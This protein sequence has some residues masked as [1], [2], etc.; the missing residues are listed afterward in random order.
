MNIQEIMMILNV[1][2][3]WALLLLAMVFATRK[4]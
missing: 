1:A 3:W 2:L 4:P